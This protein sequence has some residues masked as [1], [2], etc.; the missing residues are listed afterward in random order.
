MRLIAALLFLAFPAHAGDLISGHAR[1]IDGDTVQIGDTRIRFLGI[2]AP[3]M[4]TPDGPLAKEAVRDIIAGA[5]VTCDGLY[6]DRYG[7]TVATCKVE[8]V[9]LGEEMLRRGWAWAYRRYLTDNIRDRYIALE[10]GAR[11]D[12][13]GLWAE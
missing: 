11:M 6:L 3:E 8:E 2:D 13:V 10:E 9:D 12:G 7:R 1:V 4:K 5:F